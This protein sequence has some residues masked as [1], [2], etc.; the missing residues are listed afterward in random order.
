FGI[1]L[2]LVP[3]A[4]AARLSEAVRIPTIGIGAGPDTDGQVLVLYDLLGLNDEFAPKFLRRFAEL[5]GSVRDG[6][7]TY[8]SA[9]RDRSYPGPEHGFE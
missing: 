9:V 8:A 6:V 3:S 7:T 4:L 2:E 1:V 5:A